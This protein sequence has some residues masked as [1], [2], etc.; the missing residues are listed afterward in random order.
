[1]A[2]TEESRHRLYEALEASIG[3][4]NASTLMAHLPPI[5]WAD[6]ATKR[7]LEHVEMKVQLTLERG[8]RQQLLVLIPVIVASMSILVAAVRL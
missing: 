4:D 5:G 8:L 3:V 1:M 2:I 6:V 7:D